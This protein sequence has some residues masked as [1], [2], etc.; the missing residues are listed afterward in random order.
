MTTAVTNPP[1]AN[2]GVTADVNSIL[3]PAKPASRQVTG[4]VGADGSLNSTVASAGD[5]SVFNAAAKSLGKQDFLTLLVTQLRYQDPMQ[6][7][8]NTQ[9]V[10]QLAQFSSLEGT[11]NINTSIQDLSTKITDLV[12]NQQSSATA[13]SNASATN[14]VG[15]F[16]RA[17][18]T[19]VDYAAGQ[20]SPVQVD[21]HTDAGTDPVLSILDKDGAIVNVL[22]LQAG[23]ETAITWDGTK[24]DGS[25]APTGTYS[26]KVTSRDG[27]TQAGY[28]FFEST[29]QGISYGKDGARLE[30]NG[31]QVG[32]DQLIRVGEAPS[33]N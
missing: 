14:L 26:L 21:V 23:T 3:N 25:K 24:M 13:I 8:D 9:F 7:E 5:Q 32:M 18:A 31:Q 29:I 19:S 10:A 17:N 33:Q 2:S 30:M 4:D 15:K 6:P 12:T 1:A 11:Q 22:P 16:A 28:P 27:S 20:S